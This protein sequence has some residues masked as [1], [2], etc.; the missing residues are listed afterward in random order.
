MERMA[1][2][3]KDSGKPPDP[4]GKKKPVKTT[5][6]PVRHGSPL[7]IWIPQRIRRHI[8]N[9]RRDK[10]RTLTTEILIALEDHLR[11]NGIDPDSEP[12]TDQPQA[13]N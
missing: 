11:A 7:R 5:T 8:D 9:L 13:D 6:Q 12:A 10:R 3:R 1:T 2:P 4:S